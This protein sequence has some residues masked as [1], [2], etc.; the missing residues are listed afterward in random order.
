MKKLLLTLGLIAIVAVG[1]KKEDIQKKEECA[2]IVNLTYW[3]NPNNNTSGKYF[4]LSNCVKIKPI[5]NLDITYKV[6]DNVCYKEGDIY[7]P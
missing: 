1:C 7:K 2:N 6:G 3:V 4:V 5:N